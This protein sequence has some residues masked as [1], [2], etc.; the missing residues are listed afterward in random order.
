MAGI[1]Y[2]KFGD[3]IMADMTEFQKNLRGLKS[4]YK[5]SEAYKKYG[6]LTQES[7]EASSFW[8]TNIGYVAKYEYAKFQSDDNK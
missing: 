8:K 7:N 2:L 1:P 6:D 3:I 5:K 4:P